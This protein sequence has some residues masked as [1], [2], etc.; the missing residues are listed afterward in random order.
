MTPKQSDLQSQIHLFL[1]LKTVS[2]LEMDSLILL[3]CWL[4][5]IYYVYSSF[6]CVYVHADV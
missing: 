2:V 4:M 5:H 3:V 6:R 1:V